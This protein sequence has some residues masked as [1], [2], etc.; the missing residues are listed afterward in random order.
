MLATFSSSSVSRNRFLHLA[1]RVCVQAWKTLLSLRKS[2]S[3]ER[4]IYISVFTNYR[5]PVS[6]GV[7]LE[8]QVRG[9]A[10]AGL[11]TKYRTCDEIAVQLSSFKRL[12]VRQCKSW[13]RFAHRKNY[14]VELQDLILV[15]GVSLTQDW[16]LFAYD[17]VSEREVTIKLEVASLGSSISAGLW[18]HWRSEQCIHTNHGPMQLESER[19][20]SSSLTS[21]GIEP[22]AEDNQCVFIGGYRVRFR[23]APRLAFLMR[24]AAGPHIPDIGD[25]EDESGFADALSDMNMDLS[26]EQDESLTQEA[27]DSEGTFYT[28]NVFQI[29]D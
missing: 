17:S 14:E 5:L 25:D 11:L 24:A 18:G 9:K 22:Q 8:C 23:I 13:L 19:L 2:C 26:T 29:I 10:G 1:S 20:A 7:T 27:S 3:E 16:A 12:M 28:T 21:V 6:P 4:L 15:T